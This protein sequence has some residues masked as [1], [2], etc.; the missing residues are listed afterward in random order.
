[1]DPIFKVL[2]KK[3][4]TNIAKQTIVRLYSKNETVI[5]TTVL[6]GSGIWICVKGW[7]KQGYSKFADALQIVGA[8]KI[9][10]G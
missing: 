3:I 7:L 5:D 9:V 6:A 10:R 2:G 4:A 8:D 1:L